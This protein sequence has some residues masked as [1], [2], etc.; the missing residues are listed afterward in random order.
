M[1]IVYV[2]DSFAICGGI[3]KVLTDKMNCLLEQYGYDITLLT[4]YQGCHSFPFDINDHIRFIDIGVRLHQQYE[5]RGVSRLFVRRKLVQTIECRLKSILSE[6]RPD[7][8]VCVK[9]DFVGVL[10]SINGNIP[11]VVESHTLCRA[12]RLEGS[13]VFRRIHLWKIKKNIQRVEALV[14][15]TEGDANDWRKI[16]PNVYVIPNIVHLNENDTYSSCQSKSVIY[17]GRLSKQKNIGALLKVWEKCH[18][19]NPEWKLHVYGEI[20]D[21]EAEV[22]D[23]LL[24]ASD[25]GVIMHKP[26]KEK[27]IEEYKKHSILFLTSSYEPFGLVLPE[28]MSC[29]L[30]VVAFDCPYGPSEIISDGKDGFLID[31][32]DIDAFANK[33]CLLIED[34]TL[35]KQMGQYAIQS[36][37]RFKKE[38]IMPQWNNFFESLVVKS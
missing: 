28:A 33:L 38:K 1:R 27:M 5:Y 15:L 24:L 11:L 2:T 37:L 6:L 19:R 4:I 7:V 12:E 34:E 14:A 29:G 21:V 20:G 17:V 13:G 9:L 32:Y 26:V 10:L 18:S 36:A 30:P 31:C 8:I 16:T 22:Y 3:E 23:K 25:V 35:R